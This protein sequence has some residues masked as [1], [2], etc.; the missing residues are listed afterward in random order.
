MAGRAGRGGRCHRR[1]AMTSNAWIRSAIVIGLSALLAVLL[2]LTSPMRRL[3]LWAGDIQARIA[4]KPQPISD[5][6]LLA[7]DDASTARLKPIV[8]NWPYDRALFARVTDYLT[9]AG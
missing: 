1:T 2:M 6:V 5:A 8:G 7:I 9:R 3:D 4:A